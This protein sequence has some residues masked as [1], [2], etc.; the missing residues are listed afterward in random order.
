MIKVKVASTEFWNCETKQLGLISG[1]IH[2]LVSLYSDTQWLPNVEP[3]L[4][5]SGSVSLSL[6]RLPCA[7]RL[8]PS[9]HPLWIETF[10]SVPLS[11]TCY[12]LAAALKRPP[13][14]SPPLLVGS[15]TIRVAEERRE[16]CTRS[17]FPTQIFTAGLIKGQKL[18]VCSCVRGAAAIW[19][20]VWRANE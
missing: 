17:F 10:P 16:C 19:N 15:S 13:L 3:L 7:I 2:P 11:A 5:C 8:P 1:N 18:E 4:L 12:Q 14:P 6:H 20:L 9:S